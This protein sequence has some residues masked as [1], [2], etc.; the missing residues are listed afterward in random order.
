MAEQC[1]TS[2]SVMS[3]APNGT[4]PIDG[5]IGHGI[6]PAMTSLDRKLSTARRKPRQAI[7][8]NTVMP[9]RQ[10][11]ISV[12]RIIAGGNFCCRMSTLTWAWLA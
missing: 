12:T 10:V 11:T 4:S 6:A 3:P 8:E 5:H 2:R 1:S 9:T 7:R